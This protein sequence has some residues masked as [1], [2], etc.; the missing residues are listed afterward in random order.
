MIFRMRIV[1]RGVCPPRDTISRG[2]SQ[3][4]IDLV[5]SFDELGEQ[6]GVYQSHLTTITKIFQNFK[7]PR[8]FEGRKQDLLGLDKHFVNFDTALTSSRDRHSRT[9]DDEDRKFEPNKPLDLPKRWVSKIEGSFP[10]IHSWLY[11]YHVTK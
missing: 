2:G 4:D 10:C 7:P 11:R 8:E 6:L 3:G 1:L 9:L 5:D